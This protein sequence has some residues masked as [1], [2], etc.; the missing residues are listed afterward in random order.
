MLSRQYDAYT[1][2]N[3]SS[4]AKCVTVALTS[5]CGV[6]IFTAA[7]LGA[8]DSNN[9]QT[10]YL[11]DPGAS[12]AGTAT[13]SFNIPPAATFDLVMHEV[14]VPNT[15]CA[16]YQ[17]N[18]SGLPCPLADLSV[19]TTAPALTVPAGSIIRFPITLTNGGPNP[20]SNVTLTNTLP[21]GVS[22]V[23]L[24]PP[25]GWTC[26]TPAVGSGGSITCTKPSVSSG[27]KIVI[28]PV[29]GVSCSQGDD[30]T[31]TN[32]VA[33]SSTTGDANPFNNSSSASTMVSNPPP[34]LTVP[35][36]V[37]VTTEPGAIICARFVSDAELG[38]ATATDSCPGV[39]ITRSGVPAG[40]IFP[41][42]TTTITYTATDAGGGRATATQTVTVVDRTPPVIG[43]AS[44]T[45]DSL[46]APNHEM[47][48]I[49]VS[50]TASDACGS[51]IT[52]L[53][54]AS[55]EPVNG[56]GDGDTAPDWEIVDDHH[57][58]LRAERAGNGTGRT[59]TITITAVD[60]VGNTSAQNVVVAV[61][62]DT[63]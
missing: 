28:L 50:Y 15:G 8:F 61:P 25:P 23:S 22:F 56:T 4:S 57:V 36:N 38:T 47:V 16:S 17:F 37:T 33:V 10:N 46:W 11:A 54:V 62:H 5:G 49:I 39:T 41:V 19:T 3:P 59:Y 18:V 9:I 13:F 6:N 42:G 48:D 24:T 43:A 26:T 29:V 7:Y 14:A 58:R 1:F 12:F 20:A 2:T 30:T 35:A 34:M 55:N 31:L 40:N 60:L 53:A 51:A 32:S 52:S 63:R 27:E 21:A 44:A 45:P